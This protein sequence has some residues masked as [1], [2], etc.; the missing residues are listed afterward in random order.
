M[1]FWHLFLICAALVSCT[2]SNE[3]V[4]AIKGLEYYPLQSG[5][6]VEY[7]VD[8]LVYTE[9]PKDTLYFKYRMKEKLAEEF[10]D[11][12]GKRAFRLERY[13]KRYNPA[14]SYDSMKWTIKEVCMLSPDQYRILLQDN[15]TSFTRLIFPVMDKAVWNG[16]AYNNL[17]PQ[18]YTYEY[19]DQ[20]RDFGGKA[21]EKCLKVNQLC[22]TINLIQFLLEYECYASGLG[23]VNKVYTHL[24]SKS[25]IS[26]GIPVYKRIESG[27]S[28][29]LTYRSNGYE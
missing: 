9:L 20:N 27:S 26:G 13:I 10:T 1:K 25:N 28:Y 14:L 19:I 22:D 3:D 5:K 16:N 21:F 23:L 4:G 24:Y 17:P 12:Q 8:S 11:N 6:Y 15:N 7:D 18:N 2:K 29:T